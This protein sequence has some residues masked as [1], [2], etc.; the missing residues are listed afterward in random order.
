MYER[1]NCDDCEEYGEVCLIG[2]AL[3][4]RKC[5]RAEEVR[6]HAT[7]MDYPGPL[8]MPSYES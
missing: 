8:D 1:D 7:D 5:A 3:L 6:Q 4:C 2:D